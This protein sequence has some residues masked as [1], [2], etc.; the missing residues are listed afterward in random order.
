MFVT[1]ED[2]EDEEESEERG[3]EG[4]DQYNRETDGENNDNNDHKNLTTENYKKEY[5]KYTMTC[6]G[7]NLNIRKQD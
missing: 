2:G 7:S 1:E 5:E 4:K 6:V 3:E